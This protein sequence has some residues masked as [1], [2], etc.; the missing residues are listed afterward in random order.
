MESVHQCVILCSLLQYNR[1]F[2]SFS[3][4]QIGSQ[5]YPVIEYAEL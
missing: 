5:L 2:I 1:L 4:P 3:L